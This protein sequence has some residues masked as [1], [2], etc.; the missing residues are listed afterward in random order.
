MYF[1]SQSLYKNI[2][3]KIN[4]INTIERLINITTKEDNYYITSRFL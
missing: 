2:S 4:K 1:Q 3:T